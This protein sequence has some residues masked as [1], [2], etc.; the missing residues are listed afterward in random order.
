MAV[1]HPKHSEGGKEMHHD[2]EPAPGMAPIVG[3]LYATVEDTYR[4]LGQRV[5]GM[6]REELDD[7]D[8]SG[9]STARGS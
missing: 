1:W 3:L 6:S 4:R 2:L 7:K 9:T 8:P 5:E